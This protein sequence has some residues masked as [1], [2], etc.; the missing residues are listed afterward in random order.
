M[1]RKPWSAQAACPVGLNHGFLLFRSVAQ[2]ADLIG[3]QYGFIHRCHRFTNYDAYE[4][5]QPE[6]SD[7]A[8]DPAY[9]K[10]AIQVPGENIIE[11]GQ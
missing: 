6:C 10:D 5:Q 4:I 11:R 8:T 9:V 2:A 7:G 3:L 1:C